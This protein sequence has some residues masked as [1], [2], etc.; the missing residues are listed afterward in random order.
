LYI[1]LK[2]KI[3]NNYL[4]K[5]NR[6]LQE[7]D[8]SHNN[9]GEESGKILGTFIGTHIPHNHGYIQRVCLFKLNLRFK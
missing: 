5:K 7:L 2:F 6:L 1:N 8:L 4:L 9:F 3:I